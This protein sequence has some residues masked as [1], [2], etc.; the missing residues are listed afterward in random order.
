MFGGLDGTAPVEGNSLIMD[1]QRQ[2]NATTVQCFPLYSVL[3]ALGRSITYVMLGAS[4]REAAVLS[5]IGNPVVDYLSLD[6]EGAELLIMKT[7]PWD[8]VKIR[9]VALEYGW[10]DKAAKERKEFM[11]SK[12]YRYV[13]FWE[14][15]D[16][17]FVLKSENLTIPP[18]SAWAPKFVG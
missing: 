16:Q 1:Q 5:W 12:G 11:E 4:V 17:L 18:E 13:R 7:V 15:T 9:V 14:P 10:S 3:M 2:I 6:V 8:K